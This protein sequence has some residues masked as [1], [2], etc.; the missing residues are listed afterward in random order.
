MFFEIHRDE[1]QDQ[2]QT[3]KKGV[4]RRAFGDITNQVNH[5]AGK[6]VGGKQKKEKREDRDID[7]EKFIEDPYAR[8]FDAGIDLG[9]FQSVPHALLNPTA[10]G[11]DDLENLEMDH[12]ED[13]DAHIGL[14]DISDVDPFDLE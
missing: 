9:V 5:S 10:D 7:V 2:A 12:T 14:D 8:E 4:E 6:Q 1:V 13:L 3:R 11:D